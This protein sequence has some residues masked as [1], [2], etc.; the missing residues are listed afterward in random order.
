MFLTLGEKAWIYKAYTLKKIFKHSWHKQWE[1]FFLPPSKT[2]LSAS[3][4]EWPH[5]AMLLWMS[6]FA[7][8][9]GCLQ[10]WWSLLHPLI[11]ALEWPGKWG[12]AWELQHRAGAGELRLEWA[13]SWCFSY[14][15]AGISTHKDFGERKRGWRMDLG[16]AGNWKPEKIKLKTIQFYPY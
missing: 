6:R 4:L 3:A 15:R 12:V 11:W 5:S 16:R 8:Q 1:C 2:L 13:Y 9:W 14:K 7:E 10:R